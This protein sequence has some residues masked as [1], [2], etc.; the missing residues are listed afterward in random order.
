[1]SPSRRQ[2]PA[3]PEELQRLLIHH[4]GH[5]GPTPLER[6]RTMER[7]LAASTVATAAAAMG[8]LSGSLAQKGAA[9]SSVAASSV[10]VT[11]IVAAKWALAGAVTAAAMMGATTLV[12]HETKPAPLAQTSAPGPRSTPRA[13]NVEP[14]VKST[15]SRDELTPSRGESSASGNESS[16]TPPKEPSV[17]PFGAA[18]TG[19]ARA[20]EPNDA[21]ISAP[22]VAPSNAPLEVP[23]TDVTRDRK[24]LPS[25]KRELEFLDNARRNLL[26]QAPSAALAALADYDRAF[27]TGTLRTEASALRVEALAA[28][29]RRQEAAALARGFLAAHAESPLAARIRSLLPQIEGTAHRP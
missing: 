28:A 16:F 21:R 11:S 4:G 15:A 7:I 17:A 19:R 6:E 1:M 2:F 22:P 26:Q 29:G 13:A 23:A 8:V 9:A 25:L 10:K 27:P 20:E 24:V 12:Q 18:V 3:D 5:D 14:Q